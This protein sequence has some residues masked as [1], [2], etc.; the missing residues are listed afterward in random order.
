MIEIRSKLKVSRGAYNIRVGGRLTL[1]RHGDHFHARLESG[2][3]VV[4][5]FVTDETLGNG[6][7]VTASDGRV[8][9]VVTGEPV[10]VAAGEHDHHHDHDHGHKH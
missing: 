9:E 10:R 6:D 7:L 3:E 8:L 1:E 4:L 5:R 2:E